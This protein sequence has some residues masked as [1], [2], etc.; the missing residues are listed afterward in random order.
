MGKCCRL[1]STWTSLLT[2]FKYADNVNVQTPD[3][4]STSLVLEQS[5]DSRHRAPLPA[6][7]PK[8]PPSPK[9]RSNTGKAGM[10]F[11]FWHI[12][13]SNDYQ[14]GDITITNKA[15]RLTQVLSKYTLG[16]ATQPLIL[17]SFDESHTLTVTVENTTNE[18]KPKPT[19]F[20]C[21]RRALRA[22]IK[23]SVFSFFYRRL[24]KCFNSRSPQK[25]IPPAAAKKGVCFP[26][27]SDI[28]FDQLAL[29]VCENTLKIEDVAKWNLW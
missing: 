24:A 16:A 29:K 5:A 13:H 26:S 27:H 3:D 7:V 8:S 21:L 20:T 17:L 22:L 12:G 28:G 10:P 11:F 4:A 23:H 18:E 6:Q 9:S 15:E 2:A 1:S 19:Y 14:T 25:K